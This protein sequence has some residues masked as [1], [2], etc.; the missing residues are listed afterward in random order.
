MNIPAAFS[1]IQIQYGSLALLIIAAFSSGCGPSHD[2]PER[3][4]VSGSVTFKGQ[5]VPKGHI[6]FVPDTSK[7]NRG[8]GGGAQI[9]DG[10]Y[11][12]MPRK[13]VVGGH[14]MVTISGTDGIPTTMYGEQLKD[15]KQLFPLCQMRHEFPREDTEWD[16]VVPEKP[17]ARKRAFR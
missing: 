8:P 1:I 16:V 4:R 15:G 7:Q 3:F 2:G 12:T 10:R 9:V 17:S 13:G 5:P 6:R 11:E 14:Y